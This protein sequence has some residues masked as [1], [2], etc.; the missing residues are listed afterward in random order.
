MKRLQAPL[1]FL[2]SFGLNL[3]LAFPSL[4]PYRDAGDFGAAVS[5]IGVAHPPGYPLYVL[6][7]KLF[8][9]LLPWA[10]PLY[11][12]NV[13]S[14]V[15]VASAAVL[16][17]LS[18]ARLAGTF[19][20]IAGAF[21]FVAMPAVLSQ[22][23]LSEIY[24]LNAVI[25]AGI[26][27]PLMTLRDV[28]VAGQWRRWIL[29]SFVIGLGCGNHQTI[30]AFVPAAA[31]VLFR[32]WRIQRVRSGLVIA[33]ACL[34]IVGFSI[35]AMSF[36]RALAGAQYV[37]GEPFHLGGFIDLLTRADYGAATLS[38]RHSAASADQAIFLWF[39]S[40]MG[41]WGIS[42]VILWLAG[43]L[44]AFRR[45]QRRAWGGAVLTLWIFSGPVFGLMARLDPGELSLAILEPSMILPGIAAVVMAGVF[46]GEAWRRGGVFRFAVVALLCSHAFFYAVPAVFQHRQRQ[47]YLADDYGRNLFRT[48]P[49]RGVL[50][51]ISDGA[52]FS[53]V[54][55]QQVF[56]ERPDI[57]LIVDAPLPW[58]WRQ[59][60]QRYPELFAPGQQDG[61]RELAR[62]RSATEK[63]F[64]EG[65]HPGLV[66][67]LCPEGI[68]N[69]LA[70][71]ARDENCVDAMDA[72]A[73][74]WTF[75]ARRAPP[76]EVLAMDYYSRSI[77]KT[78]ASNAYNAGLLLR[79]AGREESAQRSFARALFWSPERWMRWTELY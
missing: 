56:R 69:A 24:V 3:Y 2:S 32:E 58:R 49:P 75:Y 34:F 22:A 48:L 59:Y 5:S 41:Q 54:S 7:G 67:S 78:A 12:L 64:T 14:A 61:G 20:G 50:L 42:G 33:M 29:L 16:V 46:I 57:R 43:A 23:G 51:M 10:N 28:P 18:L 60:R 4:S 35:N 15:C 79:Q 52:I 65:L 6:L 68:A 19:A 13:F 11:R 26:A 36:L 17:F 39:R 38:T 25:A 70:W 44:W 21:L 31:V 8:Q 40:W 9:G 77:A 76:P 47:N 72:G 1:I 66:E 37:W 63:I 73:G 53:A 45:E 27:Y 62:G 74:L 55:R 30:L 71:P